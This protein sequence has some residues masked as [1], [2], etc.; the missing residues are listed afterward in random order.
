M[1]HAN[2]IVFKSKTGEALFEATGPVPREEE[3]IYNGNKR[4]VV[5]RIAYFMKKEFLT[6]KLMVAVYIQEF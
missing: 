4:Y 5:K 6:N 3:V 2:H 1:N